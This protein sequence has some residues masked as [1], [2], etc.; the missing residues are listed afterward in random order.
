MS[1]TE[2]DLEWMLDHMEKISDSWCEAKN[3]C[4]DMRTPRCGECRYGD[5]KKPKR[6]AS[7]RPKLELVR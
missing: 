4:C 2:E 6:R 1:L 3:G 5:R 7:R